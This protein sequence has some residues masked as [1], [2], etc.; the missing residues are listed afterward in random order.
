[1]AVI[2]AVAA[3]V[4]CLVQFAFGRWWGGRFGDKVAGGQSLGQKN[5]ALAIWLTQSF[6]NPLASVAPAAYVVWQNIVNS[7]QLWR[8][9][10]SA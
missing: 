2:L 9:N 6:L 8:K 10:K 1:M 7:Y 3:L 5:M 4:I